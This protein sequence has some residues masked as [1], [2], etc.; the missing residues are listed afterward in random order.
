MN[1]IKFPNF[2]GEHNK[3]EFLETWLLGMRKYFQLHDHCAQAEGRISIYQLKEKTSMW[4]YKFMQVQYIDENKVTWRDFKRHFQ[5]DI[6][7]QVILWKENEG[8]ISSQDWEY[9]NR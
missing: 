4:L 1:K 5:K 3:N 7:I 2:H 9:E 8:F 6:L